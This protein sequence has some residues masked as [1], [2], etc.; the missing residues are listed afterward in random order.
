MMLLG[1]CFAVPVDGVAFAP[2]VVAAQGHPQQRSKRLPASSTLI[3]NLAQ[4][5]NRTDTPTT[6]DKLEDRIET[7]AHTNR[8]HL[9]EY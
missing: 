8:F 9:F 7:H 5:P 4:S 6:A 2:A 1:Y 3:D